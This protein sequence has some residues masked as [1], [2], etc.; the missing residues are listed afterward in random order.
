VKSP[1]FYRCATETKNVD[2]CPGAFCTNYFTDSPKTS[3]GSLAGEN[4]PER[5][6]AVTVATCKAEPAK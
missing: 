5:D 6:L 2:A 4:E 3:T 1:T